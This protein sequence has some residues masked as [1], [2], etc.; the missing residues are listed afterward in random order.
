[1]TP[2]DGGDGH[3]TQL[4]MLTDIADNIGHIYC[5]MVGEDCDIEQIVVVVEII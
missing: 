4:W 1:M 2:A 3:M 5:N